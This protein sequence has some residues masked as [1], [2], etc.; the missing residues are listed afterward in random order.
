MRLRRCAQG[1]SLLVILLSASAFVLD[2]MAILLAGSTLLVALAALAL[3][4]DSRFCRTV[5]SVVITRALDR[6]MV[7]KGATV[8]VTT[9]VAVQV[10]AHMQ[11]RVAENL[12]SGVVVQDGETGAVFDT[13]AGSPLQ[14]QTQKVT[15]RITP[16]VH[17]S[18]HFSGVSLTARDLFF[19]NSIDLSTEP[20]S[21][22]VL[23]VQPRGLFEPASQR[24]TAETREIEKMSVLSGFSIRAL[25]EYY[26]G[27]DLRRIDW[28]LSAKHDKLFVREYSGVMNLPP[29]II[30]DLPWR[31]APH[32]EQDFARMVAAVA[33]MAEYSVRTYQY[34][35]VLLI[36]GPNILQYLGEEKDLQRCMSVLREWMH[37][38]ERTV[39]FYRMPDRSDLRRQIRTLERR[40]EEAQDP[41]TQRFLTTLHRLCLRTVQGQRTPA[42]TAHLI[43]TLSPLMADEVYIFSLFSMD[44]SHLRHVIRQAKTM[45]LRV[46][47]RMPG[48]AGLSAGPAYQSQLGADTVE[49]F[50]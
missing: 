26:T 18:M 33:G 12:P 16:V 27:D 25:R 14:P 17:G 9:Q 32:P 36:S 21:G 48:T 23:F 43:R 15:C 37:P 2:D 3:S 29:L 28:K 30:V 24:V 47:V 50:A 20:F 35:S 44:V 1:I 38:V 8:R 4:F 45:K 6:T 31:G 22:P 11:V 19:E 40:S 41:S 7:R 34:V 39:H 13:I 5:G 42:F 49:A 46:H 10:P